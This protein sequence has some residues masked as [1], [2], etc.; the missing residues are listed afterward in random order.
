ML[1]LST[2]FWFFLLIIH[3]YTHPKCTR[4]TIEHQQLRAIGSKAGKRII[5]ALGEIG[6]L[7]WS[8]QI[9]ILTIITSLCHATNRQCIY[10]QFGL[11]QDIG[12]FGFVYLKNR[13]TKLID[14]IMIFCQ[15]LT[16][17]LT[18]VA[19]AR[20][21]SISNCVQSGLRLGKS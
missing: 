10:I 16:T 9:W 8:E 12:N 1:E 4:H 14:K 17:K 21:C 19:L 20:Q 2:N 15:L 18:L 3:C 7:Q 13:R 6:L 11:R 5:L